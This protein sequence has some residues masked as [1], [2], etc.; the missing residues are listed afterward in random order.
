MRVTHQMVSQQFIN[1]LNRNNK[2]METL[3]GQI[4]SGKKFERVSDSPSAVLQG[5]T[6][7]SSLAQVE[8]YQ[9]N[10]QD[11][12]DWSTAIDGALGNVT[13]VLHR[14]RELTVEASN[15]S[16]NESD[17][18]TF[19]VEIRSLLDQA[20]NIANTAYGSGY[21]FSG[22]D[23]NTQPYQDGTLQQTN[24]NGKEWTIGKGISVTGNVNAASVFGF[25]VD[26]KN[27]FE[28]MDALAQSL[29]NGENPGSHLN[30]IDQQL[31]HVITQRTIVGTNQNMLELAANNLDQTHLLNQKMLSNTEDTDIA[32]AF[33][34]LTLQETALKAALSAGSKMMQISLVDFLR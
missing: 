18:K 21:L 23:L 9:K 30:S 26:G 15:D 11:G 19:A 17:R 34:E 3:Q 16:N 32:K 22:T 31:E 13:D 5:L 20:G 27:L 28:T 12:I 14:I 29:E 10:A 4:T 8:Q 24:E 2:A 7:R 1:Q 33:T 6:H 25:S